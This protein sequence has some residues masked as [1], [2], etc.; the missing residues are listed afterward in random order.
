MLKKMNALYPGKCA[1]CREEIRRYSPILWDA[2][3]RK[4]YHRWCDPV[5]EEHKHEAVHVAVPAED[6]LQ[7]W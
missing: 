3:E 6:G 4:A 2:A 1:K 7:L 5:K